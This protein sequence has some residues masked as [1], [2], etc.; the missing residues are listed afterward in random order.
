MNEHN[1]DISEFF[2]SRLAAEDLEP[3]RIEQLTA[4]VEKLERDLTE[5][6]VRICRR[7]ATRDVGDEARLRVGIRDRR[8]PG[9]RQGMDAPGQQ[10]TTLQ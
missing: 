2:R 8:A 3:D 9:E 5:L 7:G 1:G 10:R 6:Q 4:E